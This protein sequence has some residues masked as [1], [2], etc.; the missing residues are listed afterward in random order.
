MARSRIEIMAC[1]AVIAPNR[2]PHTAGINAATIA[3]DTHPDRRVA[4]AHAQLAMRERVERHARGLADGVRHDRL[5]AEFLGE[6]LQPRRDMDAVA[7]RGQK[8]AVAIAQFAEDHVAGMD[9]DADADRLRAGLRRRACG[10]SRAAGDGWAGRRKRPAARF[11]RFAV[12]AE[13]RHHAVAQ[14]LIG[15][16]AHRRQRRRQP[17]RRND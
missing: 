10:S 14:E 9:A 1:A 15:R 13:D 16:A 11:V 2:A 8:K 3:D 4:A 6:L 5:T 17:P 7:D 12:H